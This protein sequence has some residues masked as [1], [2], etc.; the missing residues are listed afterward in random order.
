MSAKTKRLSLFTF[1]FVTLLH[2]AAFSSVV[3]TAAAQN[4]TTGVVGDLAAL[5]AIKSMIQD[6]PQGI[7][8]SWNDSVQFCQWPRVTCSSRHQRVTALDLSSGG[9]IGTLSP[10]IGNLSFLRSI[11]FHN[12]S[13]SGEI[14]PEIGRLFRLD[15][16]RLYNNSFE[17]NI[18]A[19]LANCSNLQALHLGNNN[20]IGKIPD[21]IGSLSKLNLLILHRNN[22]GGGIPLFIGN[23]TSLDTL[24]LGNCGLGGNI[25]DFFHRLINLRR[26][27]LPGNN[28]IG[29]L[30]PSFYNLSV[31]EQLFL[32]SNQLSGRLPM[33]LGSIMPRL[34]VLSIPDN[35]FTGPLPPSVLSSSELGV[36]DAARNNFSGKLVINSRDACSFEILSLSTNHFGSGENDEMKFIDALS[37]CNNLGVLDLGFNQMRGFLPESLG[38]LSTMLYFLSFGSNSFSGG[39]PSSVGSLSG[40][41]SLDLSSNQLTG[42]I[43]AS[44]GNLVNLRM[45]DFTNNSFSGNIPGSFGNLSLLIEL[46]MGLNELNGAI[47]LSLG[48]CNRLLG[49]TLDR[50][51]LTG[52]VPS[53]LFE[54]SS[55]SI[56]L[57]LGSNHLSGQIPREIGDLQNVKEIILANNRFSGNLPTTLGNCRSLE[58]LN[59]SNNFFQGSLPPSLSS[60]RAL[61]NLDVSR[62]NFTGRIPSYLEEIPLVNLD[63]SFNGFEGEVSNQGVFGNRSSV[64]VIGNNGLC[65]GLPE[66]RLPNCPSTNPKRKNRLSLAVILSISIVSVLICIAMVLFCVFYRRR[67]E[68]EDEVSEPN[69]GESFVQVSYEML[70]KATDGFSNKNFIGE[71]SFSSVYKG[72][73]D[74]D[75]VIVAIKV[76]NLHRKG[77]SKSFISECEAL[78]NAKHRNLTKVITCCSGID[79]QGNEFKAIVYEFMSNGTLDQWLHHEVPQLNLLQRLSVALDV[80]YALD[81]LHNHGGKTIVHCDLKPSNILLDED[82]VAHVGDFGLSKILD[83]EH[84]NRNHSSSVGVRGTIGYAAPEYGVGS[85][86]STSG[87]MYSYGILLLEMMTGKK[88]TY[89]MFQDGVG[90]HNYAKAA[91]D[92]GSVEVIDPILL[93]DDDIRS[94]KEDKDYVKNDMCCLM[95]LKIGVSCSM[96]SPRHRIDTATVIHELHLIKDAILGN[97]NDF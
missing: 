33:N 71:G 28:L 75:D 56:T 63:L 1:L 93:K 90:L 27:A 91:M 31:L 17:G 12:N 64:S 86:V 45:L 77:G 57:N 76:L 74:K 48:N 49:L 20:L 55:L 72:Y 25:P 46:H 39:L 11:R 29:N 10:S 84:Q 87:D 67:K 59:I 6:D 9:L 2:I 38:N 94:N 8:T 58:N 32:D 97:S 78:R 70:H 65:G 89:V 47:P 42:T 15:E 35:L 62:N 19:T 44:I 51:N 21:G 80:A 50:N 36:I 95:L 68:I 54:L 18:P 26:L 73:L 23:L 24:S 53:Q 5:L 61:Q 40:L 4:T 22:L 88:P 3:P 34:Q 16:L 13:F 69:S 60:L 52:D 14:P 92:D 30:P 81:Y 66:L 82:M 37:I 7:M 83:S 79:F 43:P 96:E 85:K 41:T